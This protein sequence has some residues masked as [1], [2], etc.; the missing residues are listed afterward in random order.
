MV[1]SLDPYIH[2]EFN[3]YIIIQLVRYINEFW[4]INKNNEEDEIKKKIKEDK[5]N[6]KVNVND[7]IKKIIF[8]KDYKSILERNEFKSK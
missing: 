5:N 7:L 4:F 6:L 2:I 1:R 3:K 8:F